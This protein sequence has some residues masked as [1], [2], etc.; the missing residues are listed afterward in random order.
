[1]TPRVSGELLARGVIGAD[2]DMVRARDAAA[3][4]ASNALRA[5]AS[6]AGGLD[7]IERCLHLTVY[8]VC[9]QTFVDHSWVADGAS[10]LLRVRLGERGAVARSAIGVAGLPSGAP[11]EV[12]LTAAVR[13]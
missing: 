6:V 3:V 11:I 12:E 5:V 8:L 10:E 2:V 7:R 4:A 9:D 1:M 13:P